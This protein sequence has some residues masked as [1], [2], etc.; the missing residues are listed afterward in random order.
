MLHD[1]RVFE[2]GAA[3]LQAP[4]K[5]GRS[6]GGRVQQPLLDMQCAQGLE[7]L[8]PAAA[9]APYYVASIPALRDLHE[10]V[11]FEQK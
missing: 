2:K 4:A 9:P 11:A 10:T 6:C 7:I 3:A 5:R 1:P 8:P